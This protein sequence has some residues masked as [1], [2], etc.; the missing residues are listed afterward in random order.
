MPR[1]HIFE[2]LDLLLILSADFTGPLSKARVSASVD[3]CQTREGW[4]RHI[5]VNDYG[6]LIGN[7]GF[8]THSIPHEAIVPNVEH[9]ASSTFTPL[10]IMP[11]PTLTFVQHYGSQDAYWRHPEEGYSMASDDIQPVLATI[12][13]R[14]FEMESVDL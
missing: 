2:V 10:H 14:Y 13:A 4:T 7:A 12:W 8:E 3:G 6:A 11:F 5:K 9:R 1:H